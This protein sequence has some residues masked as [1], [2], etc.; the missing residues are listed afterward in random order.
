MQRITARNLANYEARQITDGSARYAWLLDAIY[1]ALRHGHVSCG[2]FPFTLSATAQSPAWTAAELTDADFVWVAP[3]GAT[4]TGK[5][6]AAASFN[7]TGA[8]RCYCSDWSQVTEFSANGDAGF[9]CDLAHL[10]LALTY[11]N[12]TSCSSVTYAAGCL[13]SVS[14]TSFVYLNE[15]GWSENDVNAALVER[16][17]ADPQPTGGLINLSG[18]AAPTAGPPDGESAAASLTSKGVT[19]TTA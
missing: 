14:E 4:F 16:D 17:G 8:W 6:P 10:P 5:A 19:V 3:S 9:A 7:E 1:H 15:L 11:L 13:D 12:L 2:H 18:S